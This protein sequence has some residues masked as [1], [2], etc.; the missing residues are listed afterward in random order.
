MVYRQNTSGRQ[1]N[2]QCPSPRD[3]YHA[4]TDSYTYESVD[5][6]GQIT[7]FM[8]E[9]DL[10]QALN[11]PLTM[12]YF[13]SHVIKFSHTHIKEQSAYPPTTSCLRHRQGHKAST[14]MCQFQSFP[15]WNFAFLWY[16][17]F[18]VLFAAQTSAAF[19]GKS[20]NAI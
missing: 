9:L 12:N 5:I 7:V 1:E 15:H 6:M 13:A 11:E 4:Y 16:F 20:V 3:V 8:P 10:N 18:S 19:F 2:I 17:V 14:K